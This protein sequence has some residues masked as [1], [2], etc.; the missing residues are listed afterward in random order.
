[1]TGRGSP[2]IF[3]KHYK[4]LSEPFLIGKTKRSFFND[5]P[6]LFFLLFFF[7]RADDDIRDAPPR[8]RHDSELLMIMRGFTT[9]VAIMRNL[10]ANVDRG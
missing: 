5:L 10:A 6:P 2:L 3:F 4:Y 9:D 7:T 1:M 8:S